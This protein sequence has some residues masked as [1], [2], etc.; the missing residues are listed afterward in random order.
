M[1]EFTHC[2]MCLMTTTIST[3]SLVPG[4]AVIRMTENIGY[5]SGGDGIA[6]VP[7]AAYAGTKDYHLYEELPECVPDTHPEEVQEEEE[8]VGRGTAQEGEYYV[9]DGKE[10]QCTLL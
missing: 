1:R 3:H 9:N 8:N 10:V 4:Q 6:P 2:G 7:N 5:R